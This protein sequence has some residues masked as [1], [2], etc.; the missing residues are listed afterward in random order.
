MPLQRSVVVVVVVVVP[1]VVVVMVAVV[2]VKVAVDVVVM[3]VMVVVV[4]VGLLQWI[5]EKFAFS[6]PFPYISHELVAFAGKQVPST[7]LNTACLHAKSSLH[8]AKHNSCV[9]GPP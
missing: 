1:V 5:E 3:V 8:P 7:L 2:E 9:V 6:V 4:D